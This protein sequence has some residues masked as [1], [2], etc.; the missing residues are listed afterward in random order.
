MA[1][2]THRH[3]P[4]HMWLNALYSQTPAPP[5]AADAAAQPCR[6]C[7]VGCCHLQIKTEVKQLAL[8]YIRYKLQIGQCCRQHGA[9]NVYICSDDN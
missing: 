6:Y 8:S 3:M 4:G 9:D 2:H 1:A 7:L 5:E